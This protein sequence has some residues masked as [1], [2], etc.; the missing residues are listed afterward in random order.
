M[1]S[2][3][4]GMGLNLNIK[5]VIFATTTKFRRRL[6]GSPPAAAAA[7]AQPAPSRGRPAEPQAKGAGEARERS[8]SPTDE[9]DEESLRIHVRG[10]VSTALAID[11]TRPEQLLVQW[12]GIFRQLA[13]HQWPAAA[14]GARAA[15][16]RPLFTR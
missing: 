14:A 3:A 9:R 4:I 8:A 16:S 15:P 5:R 2:D 6:P 10:D 7:Q 12:M 11:A 1:A 13:A